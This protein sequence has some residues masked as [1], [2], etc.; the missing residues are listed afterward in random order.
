MRLAVGPPGRPIAAFVAVG[1]TLAAVNAYVS[2]AA[3]MVAELRPV[4]STRA[5]LPL[6]IGAVGVVALVLYAAGA[7]S[8][9][10]LVGLPTTLFLVV[11]LLCMLA[12]A[13]LLHG[14]GRVGRGGG[15]GRRRGRAGVLRLAAVRRRRCRRAGSSARRGRIPSRSCRNQR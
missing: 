6:A 4:R 3:E 8:T 11:Y 2:G 14:A 15:G 1:L 5:V 7:L 13:R 9:D 10:R 12:A